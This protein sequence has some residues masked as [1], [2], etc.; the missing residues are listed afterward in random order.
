MAGA[1]TFP[2]AVV[3]VY[4]K[5]DQCYAPAFSQP[6]TPTSS[7]HGPPAAASIVRRMCYRFCQEISQHFHSEGANTKFLPG[8][9]PICLIC[10]PVNLVVERYFVS[11]I[12][13]E[14]P[15]MSDIGPDHKSPGK[16]LACGGRSGPMSLAEALSRRLSQRYAIQWVF[17]HALELIDMGAWVRTVAWQRVGCLRIAVA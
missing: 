12:R 6:T 17:M 13:L 2:P 10:G 7:L 14:Q 1:A 16:Q 9:N 4:S 11:V 5:V 3:K 8:S 15:S